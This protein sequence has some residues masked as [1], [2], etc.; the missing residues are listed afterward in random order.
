MKL[1]PRSGFG[2]RGIYCDQWIGSIPRGLQ[3]FCLTLTLLFLPSTA[4]AGHFKVYGY[5][6]PE[7]G[8]ME[9]AYWTDYT[10][11]SDAA[12]DF[13]G[14]TGIPSEKGWRHTL[15]LE[16]G[17]TDRWTVSG[18]IDFDQPSGEPL[19]YVGSRAV[20][21]RYRFLE[22]GARFFDGAVY[23]EYYLPS[24]D[25]LGF[26]KERLEARIILERQMDSVTVTLNPKLE[27]VLSGPDVE[28]G[29]EFE[30]GAGVYVD[31]FSSI[32]PGIEFFGSLGE[33][34]NFK[35][36]DQ[37]AHYVVPMVKWGLSEHLAWNIG[38][39]F[40]L[41]KTSDDLVVKSILEWEL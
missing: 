17:M 20:V 8:E 19:K 27:K 22:R 2:I 23:L 32:R 24:P 25:V 26:A 13:F 29:L 6:T 30:Y 37:Q 36:R 21:T 33:L 16:Y 39:A 5:T 40:G 12:M 15:E 34:V 38:L 35:S 28:E 41:T 7:Q 3:L 9:L 18:Y 14:S 31:R 1:F 10:I 4:T 11:Q